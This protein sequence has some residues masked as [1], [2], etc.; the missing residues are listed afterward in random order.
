LIEFKV[1]IVLFRP[2]ST[3]NSS[4][5][6]AFLKKYTVPS[7]I[8]FNS[9]PPSNSDRLWG[10][11]TYR[12]SSRLSS[13]EVPDGPTTF[14]PPHHH[15]HHNDNEVAGTMTNSNGRRPSIHPP[16]LRPAP[17]SGMASFYDD[18]E[19]LSTLKVKN[20]ELHRLPPFT[21]RPGPGASSGSNNR[22]VALF[23][24][25]EL[26]EYEN[27][28]EQ[29]HAKLAR[30]RLNKEHPDRIKEYPQEE[31]ARPTPGGNNGGFRPPLGPLESLTN[32]FRKPH[33][34]PPPFQRI[35][36]GTSAPALRRP[37]VPQ[38]HPAAPN[39]PGKQPSSSIQIVRHNTP[40]IFPQTHDST[41][42]PSTPQGARLTPP[43][44]DK[45]QTPPPGSS[46][47]R[48]S[49]Y[50]YD[51]EYYEDEDEEDA[52]NLIPP[53]QSDNS[54]NNANKG[55]R[56]SS[57]Q[58]VNRQPIP[59]Q[60][61]P[62]PQGSHSIG[63]HLA[64]NPLKRPAPGQ[65]ANQ[66]G[67]TIFESSVRPLPPPPPPSSSLGG[68]AP[69]TEMEPPP[70]DS[71][72]LQSPA[73]EL[74]SSG[75]IRYRPSGPANA[76]DNVHRP[77]LL[78]PDDELFKSAD[79]NKRPPPSSLSPTV[80]TIAS[81]DENN[82]I[83][84]TNTF[85]AVLPSQT[86]TREIVQPSRVVQGGE[87][88]ST[89]GVSLEGSE[90]ANNNGRSSSSSQVVKYTGGRL[91]TSAVAYNPAPPKEI[92]E[93][94]PVEEEE[95]DM[96]EEV[97]SL[98]NVV[99]LDKEKEKG[100]KTKI[101]P[102]KSSALQGIGQRTRGN[103]QYQ[104]NNNASVSTPVPPSS[105]RVSTS[106]S[107]SNSV[108]STTGN[109]RAQ[110]LNRKPPF[111]STTTVQ[112][113]STSSS[114]EASPHN[115]TP[116][117]TNATSKPGIVRR[118][119]IPTRPP[120]NGVMPWAKRTQSTTASTVMVLKEEAE[121]GGPS[122]REDK[123]NSSSTTS[124]FSPGV[125]T[126]NRVDFR[127]PST[128][129]SSP[130]TGSSREKINKSAAS[131]E[132][133]QQQEKRPEPTA[134]RRPTT[135][136]RE[137]ISS[138]SGSSEENK[139]RFVPS[140]RL[141][142]SS[143]STTSPPTR[144]RGSFRPSSSIFQNV[145]TTTSKPLRSNN[146][147]PLDE[148]EEYEEYSY[149]V[150]EIVTLK[151]STSRNSTKST[152]SSGSSGESSRN[153]SV[154]LSKE[155]ISPTRISEQSQTPRQSNNNNKNSG[156]PQHNHHRFRPASG[157]RP[158]SLDALGE[159]ETTTTRYI[160]STESVTVT[161]T[162]T[163]RSV[164]SSGGIPRTRTI[165]ITKTVPPLTRISTV[166]GSVTL[167]NTVEVRPTVV[168][169]TI[170]SEATM[171]LPTP[172]FFD[173]S[174]RPSQAAD[175]VDLIRQDETVNRSPSSTSTSLNTN[176]SEKSSSGSKQTNLLNAS[177]EGI[178]TKARR[179]GLGN[180]GALL[181]KPEPSPAEPGGNIEKRPFSVLDGSGCRAN[182]SMTPNQG[183]RPYAN[184]TRTKCDCKAGYARMKERFPCRRKYHTQFLPIY[185]NLI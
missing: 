102:T 122:P 156:Q 162:E 182:C 138:G 139:S 38:R 121:E 149:E 74:P 65:N 147:G 33:P 113:S 120:T 167:V 88:I 68:G 105:T 150:E 37:F 53:K 86:L 66:A 59:Q 31:K 60:Q 91:Q 11:T 118:P 94:S 183:C 57:I 104:R 41:K 178:V 67:F 185:I 43:P 160:T 23:R 135:F 181:P 26:A 34:Q 13:H 103:V 145:T 124:R 119:F 30:D 58:L 3:L 152:S 171:K 128:T 15:Q 141:T 93:A 12:P 161:I 27:S 115:D 81:V 35:P 96:D 20:K 39:P 72:R 146:T 158:S 54:K 179:P 137:R 180:N 45:Q 64:L 50:I 157:V 51:S 28:L 21:R 83:L 144:S 168:R 63:G 177:G 143:T 155:I 70:I 89:S 46:G 1:L 79:R 151:P 136:S 19:A 109:V 95:E 175:D 52:A 131:G 18:E 108:S 49:S 163:E 100:Q 117:S 98:E 90:G 112:T 6:K 25:Q 9:T 169:T 61:Q 140:R 8:H 127:R 172:T 56:T 99:A 69:S 97:G 132:I 123:T 85:T 14:R 5:E 165:L 148:D 116:P 42:V 126:G 114:S 71:N 110:I 111:R 133:K 7:H 101:S 10:P 125:N 55:T 153:S 80:H 134:G 176:S 106:V 76:H 82:K 40:G 164:F 130:S 75:P 129:T 77:N 78:R 107:T 170:L 154:S 159:E 84:G 16:S 87:M 17:Q 44:G 2:H 184:G 29:H 47:H 48:E 4:E 142:T 174:E 24:P 36:D 73:L 173:S 62:Q 166:V 32:L 22:I 92:P